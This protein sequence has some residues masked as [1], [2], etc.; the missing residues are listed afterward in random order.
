M[1]IGGTRAEIDFS[2]KYWARCKFN[3]QCYSRRQAG[4]CGC[5]VFDVLFNKVGNKEAKKDDD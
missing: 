4:D 5:M 1:I 3:R 2:R